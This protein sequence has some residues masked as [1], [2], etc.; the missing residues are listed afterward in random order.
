MSDMKCPFCQ[1]ELNQDNPQSIEC[2]ND[3]CKESFFMYGSKELWQE[4]ITTRKALD[5]AVDALKVL[6]D[7]YF[8]QEINNPARI[9]REQIN[10][11]KGGK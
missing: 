5:V 3:N 7:D 9:A 6:D 10:E 4:L 1:Q 2:K 11:I 8:P